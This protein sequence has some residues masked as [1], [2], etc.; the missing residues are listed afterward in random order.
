MAKSTKRL[1]CACSENW[2][3]P[4]FAMLGAKERVPWGRESFTN[5]KKQTCSVVGQSFVEW[6]IEK[7]Y[8]ERDDNFGYLICHCGK[9]TWNTIS[10]FWGHRFLLF[11]DLLNQ[12]GLAVM[13]VILKFSST[14]ISSAIFFL[15][16]FSPVSVSW[17]FYC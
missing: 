12:A 1:L 13:S 2:P 3:L 7:K 5:A 15:F 4:E 14:H 8:F 11:N 9:I 16:G 6:R 10:W 17:G